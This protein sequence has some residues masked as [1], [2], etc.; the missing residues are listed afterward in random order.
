MYR[1]VHPSN[2]EDIWHKVAPWIAQ[3]IGEAETWGDLGQIKAMA[4]AGAARIWIGYD[5]QDNVDVVLVSEHGMVGGRQTLILRWLCGKNLDQ[6]LQDIE[7]IE[8][9][10]IAN[11]YQSIHI[12]G[13]A[14]WQK[15]C[16]PLG[17]THEFTIIGKPLIRGLH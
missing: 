14:G 3:A 17:Y 15:V 6:W 7:M 8:G 13:R 5:A 10:A 12:W 4:M 1:L 2:V 9:W 16:K 11:G